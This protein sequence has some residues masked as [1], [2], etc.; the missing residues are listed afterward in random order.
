MS[1]STAALPLPSAL[2][3]AGGSGTARGARR[4]RK[5]GYGAI[6]GAGPARGGP[7]DTGMEFGILRLRRGQSVRETTSK[8]TLWLLMAGRAVL[9]AGGGAERVRRSDLF[10][11]GPSALHAGAGESVALRA[12]SACEFLVTRTANA[13]RI[14][15]RFYLP[16]DVA[17][18]DR[19]AALAQGA[20]RRFVRTIFDHSTRPDSRLV[21]GEVVNFPG[22]WSTYPPHHHPQPEIYHYRF[23]EPQGYGHAELGEQ[24]VKVRGGDTLLIPGGFDHSQVSAPGYGMYYFWVIRHLPGRPYLGFEFTPEHRWLLDPARQGWV[25]RPEGGKSR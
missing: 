9:R 25:P 7:F 22:R 6:T 18:E 10:E 2:L 3:H 23:T 5:T 13:R 17:L 11:E 20:C 14:G 21:A 8:E 19:G 4:P 24:V 1:P 16:E 12:E 15:V